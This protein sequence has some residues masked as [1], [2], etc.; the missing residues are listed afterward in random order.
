MTEYLSR[1]WQ[2]GPLFVRTTISYVAAALVLHAVIAR[3]ASSNIAR[4]R[5]A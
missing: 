1:L 5:E 2:W 4:G 3:F